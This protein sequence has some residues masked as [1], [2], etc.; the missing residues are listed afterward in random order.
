MKRINTGGKI[1]WHQAKHD[2]NGNA[3]IFCSWFAFGETY[4]EALA[5]AHKIGGRKFNNKQFERGIVFQG[6]PQEVEYNAKRHNLLMP[7]YF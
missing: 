6:T 1:D 2:I 5:N 4:A 3:R 7:G